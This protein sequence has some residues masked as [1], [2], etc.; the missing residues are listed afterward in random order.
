MQLD[1]WIPGLKLAI[2][3][4][5]FRKK[6]NRIDDKYLGERERERERER[7]MIDCYRK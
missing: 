1:V 3:Y 2:E 5:G 6:R 7:E 4:Q